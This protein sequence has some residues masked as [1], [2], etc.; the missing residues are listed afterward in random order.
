L[1]LYRR[2]ACNSRDVGTKDT[3]S[4]VVNAIYIGNNPVSSAAF[5]TTA[6]GSEGKASV[7]FRLA[8]S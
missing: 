1:F 3:K 7:K 6:E 8:L 2:D 5:R 4:G